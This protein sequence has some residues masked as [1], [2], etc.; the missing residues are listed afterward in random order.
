[1]ITPEQNA[2]W[3]ELMSAAQQGD[4][5]AYH[6]LL[7]EITPFVRNVLYKRVGQHDWV[8]DV[9]QDVLMGLHHARH[10]YDPTRPFHSWML[11]IARYKTMDAL[12]KYYRKGDVEFADSDFL[13]TLADVSANTSPDRHEDAR[14]LAEMFS[15]LKPKQQR[16]LT[17]TKLQGRAVAEVAA[18]ENMSES[19]VKVSVHRALKELKAKF[20]GSNET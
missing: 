7:T 13:V 9:L 4:Q 10:T 20:G 6:K 15:V 11:A 2:R 3:A 18:S 17:L 8:E 1:M 19:T 16:L 12:R 14:D 5:K